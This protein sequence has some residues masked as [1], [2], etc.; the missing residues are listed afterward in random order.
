ME[1]P[2]AVAQIRSFFAV[3]HDPR[4]PHAT[5]LHSLEALITITILATI[6]GA[7]NWVEIAHWGQARQAW[8]SE[9]LDLPHGIPAHDTFGRVFA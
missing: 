2:N 3:V 5:T 1:S 9:F 6:C 4:R 8:F 7:Q